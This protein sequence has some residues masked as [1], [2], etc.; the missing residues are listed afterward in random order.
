MTNDSPGVYLPTET[1]NVF[2]STQLAN[3][4]WYDEGQHG[5]AVA[6]LVAGFVDDIPTLAPMSVSRLSLEIFRIVPLTPLKLEPSVIREGKRIQVLEVRITGPDEVEL[7][8]AVVQRLRTTDL[9]LP[10]DVETTLTSF[11]SPSGLESADGSIWGHGPIDKVMFHRHAVE[12]REI[13]G[14]FHEPGEGSLWMKVIVPIIAGKDITPLQRMVVIADFCNGVSRLSTSSN[15]IFMNPDLTVHALGY[16]AS[17]W[18]A[19]KAKSAYSDSGR[20]FATGTLWDEHQLIGR[21]IQ[22]LFVDWI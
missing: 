7:A 17:E 6:A 19:L 5:G 4:G 1:P 11:P 3:A 22:T 18:V 20:G 8:R 12:V 10:P 21:S 9:T 16:P 14:G 15:L 13:K 2:E